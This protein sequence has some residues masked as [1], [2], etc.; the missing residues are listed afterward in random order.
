VPGSESAAR[1]FLASARSCEATRI[2]TPEERE[3]DD[4]DFSS[5]LTFARRPA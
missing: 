3:R 4:G 1:L 2:A 5:T